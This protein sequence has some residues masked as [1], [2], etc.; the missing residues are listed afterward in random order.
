MWCNEGP[1][2]APRPPPPPPPPPPGPPRARLSE[3]WLVLRL[4]ADRRRRCRPPALPR[5]PRCSRQ[6]RRRASMSRCGPSCVTSQR[7]A[8]PSG[9]CRG[10]EWDCGPDTC[11][12]AATAQS[13][14]GS[15]RLTPRLCLAPPLPV[16][17]QVRPRCRP[18]CAG[19][20]RLARP[21]RR[22]ALLPDGRGAG[23]RCGVGPP[24]RPL[25]LLPAVCCFHS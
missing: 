6:R 4:A 8:A 3:S 1:P 19:G 2:P 23:R 11:V 12:G 10:P 9:G 18:A 24:H 21:H 7:P 15:C 5:L 25:A 13:I 20:L 16:P 17:T 22:L 14:R